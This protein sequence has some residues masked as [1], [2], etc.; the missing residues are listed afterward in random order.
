M[1]DSLHVAQ[2]VASLTSALQAKLLMNK[3][4][5]DGRRSH[6]LT[7]SYWY[8]A[9]IGSYVAQQQQAHK[10]QGLGEQS[11]EEDKDDEDKD[12]QKFDR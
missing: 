2:A 9:G 6:E 11:D 4:K 8:H 10:Q 3:L 7:R 1:I 5:P 12:Q